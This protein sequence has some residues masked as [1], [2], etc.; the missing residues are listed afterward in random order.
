MVDKKDSSIPEFLLDNPSSNKV[1]NQNEQAKL[2]VLVKDPLAAEV[3]QEGSL[4]EREVGLLEKGMHEVK[5]VFSSEPYS[6]E[7]K[8]SKEETQE[9]PQESKGFIGK[10]LE[11]LGVGKS[12][13]K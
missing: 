2:T 1:M 11:L 3:S 6:K 10:T 8:T 4:K 13:D 12:E 5:K 7:I 9:E